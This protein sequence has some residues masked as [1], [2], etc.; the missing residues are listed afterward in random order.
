MKEEFTQNINNILTSIGFSRSDDT[1]EFIKTYT[2]PGQVM[3]V[4]GRRMEQPGKQLTV[5]YTIQDLGD[6]Y[7]ENSDGSNRVDNTTYEFR[8]VMGEELL[9]EVFIA[10]SWDDIESFKKDLQNILQIC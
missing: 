10:Y 1:Y 6:G 8:V 3:I 9:S 2:Q 4:N 5:K 7:C